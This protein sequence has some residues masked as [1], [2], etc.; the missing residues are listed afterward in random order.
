LNAPKGLGRDAAVRNILFGV[1]VVLVAFAAAAVAAALFID[2]ERLRSVAVGYMQRSGVVLEIERVE[3]SVG[4][5]PRIEVRGLVLR[6][7]EFTDSP[8]LE[9]EYAAFNLDLLSFLF[10]PVTLRDIVIEKPMVVLPVADEGLLY[11]GPAIASLMERLR[12]FDWALH[13]FSIVELETEALHTVRD[14]R[15]LMTAASIEGTMPHISDLS[16]RMRDIGGDLEATLPFP[17]TGSI[18][19]DEA[20][21]LHTDS[22]SSVTLEADGRIGARPLRIRAH[23]GNVLKGDPNAR[24]AIN[25]TLELAASTLQVDGTVS[26]GAEPHFELGVDIG[27]DDLASLSDSHVRFALSDEGEAW[28]L[29]DLAAAIGDAT[30][31]GGLRIERRVPRP[32]LTGALKVAGLELGSTERSGD[33]EASTRDVR[34]PAV[35]RDDSSGSS[36]N[37]RASPIDIVELAIERLD[38]VDAML[39]LEAEDLKLFAVPIRSLRGQVQLSGGRLDLGPIDAD[40]LAGAADARLTFASGEAARR[41]ELTTSF[42]GVETSELAA[43]LGIDH[44]VFGELQGSLELN[45]AGAASTSVF[46]AAAGSATL[47]MNG[48]RLSA[49]LAHLVDMDFAERIL[50]TFKSNETTPIRCAIA[51]FEGQNGIFETQ[52][53][54]VDTGEVKLVGAGMV[55]LADG[56]LD[57]VLRPYGKDFSLLSADAPLRVSGRL[58]K[59]DVSPEKGAVAVSLLTPIEMGRVENADC[60]ALIRDASDAI[61]DRARRSSARASRP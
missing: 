32:L 25:A 47:L 21:L 59:P 6:E 61:S 7:P 34:D 52:T 39:D 40:V 22:E 4:L 45:S 50:D 53:L 11:W 14:A 17:I 44:E 18:D 27:V 51:D 35:D 36:E 42:Q 9:I 54:I 1:L 26:R 5:S 33:S 30:V 46:D 8:L 10:E 60:Q 19:I 57:L 24:N 3:R 49:A 37:R 41:F 38:R 12:R 56:T 43:A 48:G 55:N 31:S 29:S 16:L 13:G 2:G 20:R 58:S 28:N 23:S 15:V